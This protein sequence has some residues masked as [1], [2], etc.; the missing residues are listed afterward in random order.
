[1]EQN[2]TTV[3]KLEHSEIQGELENPE[4]IISKP[5]AKRIYGTLEEEYLK[6]CSEQEQISDAA[7]P[8]FCQC[9][10]Q[11]LPLDL[12][13][14][15]LEKEYCDSNYIYVRTQAERKNP[16]GGKYIPAKPIMAC[17]K[18]CPEKAKIERQRTPDKT[19]KEAKVYL[20]LTGEPMQFETF[21]RE[22]NPVGFDTCFNFQLTE[23][24]ILFG[25]TGVGKTHLARSV[26]IKFFIAG[27]NVHWAT[28]QELDDVFYGMQPWNE[29]TLTKTWTRKM[30]ESWQGAECFF[31]D[32]LGSEK[33]PRGRKD[34]EIKNEFFRD[35]F[36]ELLDKLRGGLVITT[37]LKASA[38]V[39][40]AAGMAGKSLEERYGERIFSRLTAN[41][42][43]VTLTG[44]DYRKGTAKAVSA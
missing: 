17:A 16:T 29:D 15:E 18:M 40:K 12:E 10:A 35:N 6:W 5:E 2:E 24:M 43:G 33:I 38:K 8:D 31:I 23:R 7:E 27:F 41:T 1:M 30:F 13:D 19:E 37:N 22:R 36:K 4:E 25:S 34:E 26:Y 28:V 21:S 9:G 44:K 20:T 11:I 3:E 14:M 32:D 39:A 42:I